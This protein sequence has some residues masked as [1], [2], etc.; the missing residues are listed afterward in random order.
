MSERLL[1][2]R[3]ASI[4]LTFTAAQNGER[5]TKLPGVAAKEFRMTLELETERVALPFTLEVHFELLRLEPAKS[6]KK[7]NVLSPL[8]APVAEELP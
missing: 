5:P 4:A 6:S 3:Y 1:T 7:I 8:E 2:C